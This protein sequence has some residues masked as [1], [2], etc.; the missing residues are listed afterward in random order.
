MRRERVI[1]IAERVALWTGLALVGVGFALILDPKNIYENISAVIPQVP[2]AIAMLG[3]LPI[4]GAVD[5]VRGF[6]D[7]SLELSGMVVGAA[8]VALGLISVISATQ[9]RAR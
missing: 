8:S 9:P 5:A 2:Q 1:A 7:L 3:L 6:Y 4:K